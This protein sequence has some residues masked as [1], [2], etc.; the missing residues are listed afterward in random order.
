MTR[1]L[2][3]CATATEAIEFECYAVCFVAGRH[4]ASLFEIAASS[5]TAGANRFPLALR[6]PV[7][8][9]RRTRLAAGDGIAA[10]LAL[11]RC[12]GCAKIGGK[13]SLYPDKLW[14]KKL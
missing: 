6:S 3:Q 9:P 13:C 4:F 2:A 1:R 5:N 12:G 14:R 11:A 8:R 7:R 10:R